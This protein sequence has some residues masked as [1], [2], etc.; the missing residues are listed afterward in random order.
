M[1]SMSN[2]MDNSEIASSLT[3]TEKTVKNH[4]NHIFAKLGVRDRVTAVL[5]WQQLNQRAA[6][7]CPPHLEIAPAAYLRQAP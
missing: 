5:A 6:D 1:E 2:G 7:F 4:I 3:I